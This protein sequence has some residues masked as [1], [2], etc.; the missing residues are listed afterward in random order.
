MMLCLSEIQAIVPMGLVA[1]A[2]ASD[3]GTA[4]NQYLLM[5]AVGSLAA[6]IVY[7]HKSNQNAALE[8]DRADQLRFNTFVTHHEQLVSKINEERD[9]M[10]D[11]RIARITMLIKL[12]ADNSV[13]IERSATATN[14]LTEM[15]RERVSPLSQN[16]L[17]Q[18]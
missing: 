17:H 9:R 5:L 12:V 8:K 7:L 11:E 15:I 13:A 10:T 6:V 16:D 14:S 3:A 4:G 1:L 2:E 18:K